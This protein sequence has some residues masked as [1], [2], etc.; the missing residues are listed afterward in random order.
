MILKPGSVINQYRLLE[1]LGE[2]G[3]GV[4]FKAWD[5]KLERNVALK[6]LSS[7]LG[8]EPEAR[9]RLLVEAR[10][11]ARLEHPNICTVY[12]CGE[13]EGGRVFIAMGFY[14]GQPL[15][16]L[17][18]Q[19][20][21]APEEAVDLAVQL[22]RGLAAAHAKGITHR[23]VKPSNVIVMDDG[24]AKLIDFGI[25][26]LPEST[27]TKTGTTLGTTAYMSP[28]QTR[29][30]A[31]AQ[32]DLW[33][34]GVVLFEVITGRRP[35][36][37]PYHGALVFDILYTD[38]D[39]SAL[40]ALASSEVAGVVRR[41]LEKDLAKRY[42]RAD[43]VVADLERSPEVLRLQAPV[44]ATGSPPAARPTPELTPGPTPGAGGTASAVGP[45][46][47]PTGAAA[48]S[49]A[50]AR[51]SRP[52]LAAA[53]LVVAVLLG[54]LALALA[55]R[56][57][58]TSARASRD[59]AQQDSGRGGEPETQTG[60]EAQSPNEALA[61]DD[62]SQ[63]PGGADASPL[64]RG[65]GIEAPAPTLAES[66]TVSL[67][68]DRRT[69]ADRQSGEADPSGGGGRYEETPEETA[70]SG[71]TEPSHL[72]SATDLASATL[73][74]RTVPAGEVGIGREQQSGTARFDVPPGDHEVTF[75]HPTYGSK[76]TRV[77]LAAGESKELTCFFEAKVRVGT[78]LAAG[79][80]PAPFATVWVDGRNTGEFTP[81]VLTLGPG[82][83][84]IGVRRE[85]Y[86][87]LEP[88][89]TITVEPSFQEIS[90]GLT[91]LIERSE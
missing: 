40:E 30:T 8:E 69:G 3:M 62:R 58:P 56:P 15:Q 50:P 28:E 82:R 19:R 7:R 75:T 41:C 39:L 31:T 43:E 81:A 74:A 18:V 22:G 68:E 89:R 29:G 52:A 23:D 10:A 49:P 1:P 64:G 84:R 5:T 37:S 61:T 87:T 42:Q 77:R 47:L 54:G 90:E 55:E 45:P 11:V 85:G 26:K 80:G 65:S 83:Y 21:L 44:D 91:F 57:T 63:R 71:R 14:E 48:I 9:E 2:G 88:E 25:A 34:L 17:I 78:R 6:F 76:R 35:F 38:A 13:T 36:S 67:S 53:I 4:V 46:P 60:P 51:R 16:R 12:E 24:Q 20:T 70:R 73:I 27:L 86:E 79:E 72:A 33:S 59:A 66:S 32:S